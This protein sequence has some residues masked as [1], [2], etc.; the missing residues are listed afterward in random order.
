MSFCSYLLLS[1]PVLIFDSRPVTVLL[2]VLVQFT[3]MFGIGG[4]GDLGGFFG[5]V[6]R[7]GY[8]L[9]NFLLMFFN[10]GL[11]LINDRQ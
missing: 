3:L 9:L 6:F 10:I 2:L 1:M 8:G 4:G 11:N 7:F 5:F